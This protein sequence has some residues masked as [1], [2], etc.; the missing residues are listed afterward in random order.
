MKPNATERKIFVI[1]GVI[2]AALLAM[3]GGFVPSLIAGAATLAV[4]I[5]H[6]RLLRA[7]A[8]VHEVL[9]ETGAPQNP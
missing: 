5:W 2:G 6:R 8:S 3:P 4:Y 7:E 9:P 1:C